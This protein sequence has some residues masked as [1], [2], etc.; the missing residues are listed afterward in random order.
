M[1]FLTIL[2]SLYVYKLFLSVLYMTRTFMIVER[3][4]GAKTNVFTY[5][6]KTRA[7]ARPCFF[8]SFKVPFSGHRRPRDL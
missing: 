4:A 8:A 2:L 6:T 7:V 3:F 1:V 5:L